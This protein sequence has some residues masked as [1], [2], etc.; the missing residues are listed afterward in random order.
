MRDLR[1][2]ARVCGSAA[3]SCLIALLPMPRPDPSALR[4]AALLAGVLG[5]AGVPALAQQPATGDDGVLRVCADPQS[6]PLSNRRQEGYENKIAELLAKD[7]GWKLEYTWFPQRMGFIRNTLRAKDPAS[8]RFKCDLVI[9]V[10]VGFELASTTKAYFRSTYALA[11]VR[12]R[13][14]DSVKAPEDLLKLPP[15]KL[16]RLKFGVFMQTP[17]VDW[18]LR[19]QLFEQAVSY[20]RQSGDPEAYPGEIIEKDLSAGKIDVAFAWGPIAGYFAR[21]AAG[22]NIAVV[23]FKPDPEIKFDYAIA[24]GVRFGERDWKARVEQLVEKNRPQIQAILA[25][26]G[27]PLL[28][29]QGNFIVAG[30]DPGL[31]P[32]PG[33]AFY[34]V[35]G[36]K[37]DQHTYAG[38]RIFQNDCAKCH[39]PAAAGTELAPNLL[40]IVGDM[41][42]TRFVGAVLRRYQLVAP[43]GEAGAELG[44]REAL[45]EDVINRKR[46]EVPMPAWD[47]DPNVKPHILDLYSY[48][49]AR[50]DGALDDSR[51]QPAK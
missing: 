30:A 44:T 42:E 7:L 41:S 5:F 38:W 14:L 19:H 18:L 33:S 16:S 43:A 27:A 25:S 3:I 37:V 9:G 48:L 17:P 40:P 50:A 11:Y 46:G 20:Q 6:L 28:D 26:Y 8:D 49:R 23:P 2:S 12:G 32:S 21:M 24:M 36:G 15:E 29:E 22:G 45:I 35:E 13:G 31:A 39:G 51:P 34:R 1:L 47:G 10:P 4:R